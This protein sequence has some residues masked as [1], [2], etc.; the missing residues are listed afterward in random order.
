MARIFGFGIGLII[1]TTTWA[2][3]VLLCLIFSRRKGFQVGFIYIVFAGIITAILHFWPKEPCNPADEPPITS[4][5][6]I[7]VPGI[8]RFIFAGIL[9]VA[10]IFSTVQWMATNIATPNYAKKILNVRAHQTTQ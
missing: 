6:V 5:T 2:I 3:M 4:E 9:L 1:L 8:P 7:D 10:S